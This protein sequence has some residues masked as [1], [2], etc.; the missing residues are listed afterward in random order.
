MRKERVQELLRGY[1]DNTISD[2][3]RKELY[4]FLKDTNNESM[5]VEAL[6]QI[7]NS[8]EIIDF[9]ESHLSI[10]DKVYQLDR[11]ETP[12]SNLNLKI[13][14]SSHRVHFLRRGFFRYA[15]AIIFLVGASSLLYLISNEK[16]KKEQTIVSANKHLESAEIAPGGEKALLT[17][18]DGN[19]IVLENAAN[20]QLANQGG[21]KI[22][23]LS[24]GQVSYDL[25]GLSVKE[26]MLNTMSTPKGGQYQV[27]LPDGTKVWLN[28]SSSITFPTAFIDNKRQVKI[29]GEIYFEI[30]KNKE[31]PFI[32]DVNGLTTVQVLGTSFNVNS[33]E[34]EGVIKTTLVDG[35]IRVNNNVILQP[36][37]QAIITSSEE[38]P[39]VTNADLDQAL[40]WK[41]GIFDFTGNDLKNVMRQLERWYDI[42]VEYKGSVSNTI[43]K[44]KM[45]RNTNLSDVLEM[46]KRM[47][48]KFE[49]EG[50]TLIVY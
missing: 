25:S 49:L 23:K 45:Y 42:K 13:S 47:G 2:I 16:E 48:V 6:I 14:T 28:A 27:T 36:G 44:G 43:F 32:V 38:K 5:F 22:V 9:D 41:N 17:L 31:K 35:S 20:G 11:P 19:K 15:A 8:T 50:K 1:A 33:Y 40:A 10:L 30:A 29:T 18:A 21:V 7:N 39:N 4:H 24:N 37:Q 46:L 34:N 12:V 3:E 26:T